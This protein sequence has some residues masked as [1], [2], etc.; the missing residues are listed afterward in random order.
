[1]HPWRPSIMLWIPAFLT[2]FIHSLQIVLINP[3]LVILMFHKKL[4]PCNFLC[5]IHLMAQMSCSSTCSLSLR[6]FFREDPH[7]IRTFQTQVNFAVGPRKSQSLESSHVP[8]S[9]DN[10]AFPG[11]QAGMLSPQG[12]IPLESS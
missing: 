4:L 12:A 1:M 6:R 3:Y 11:K 7:R 10:A 9:P 5:L 2:V 8:L